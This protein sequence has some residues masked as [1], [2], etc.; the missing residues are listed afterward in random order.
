MNY[1]PKL[2]QFPP[3]SPKQ[4]RKERN[5][6]VEEYLEGNIKRFF[7]RHYKQY[8]NELVYSKILKH[9][10]KDKRVRILNK[11]LKHTEWPK[12]VC[13]IVNLMVTL[14][15]HYD[16]TY[17]NRC[18]NL[19]VAILDLWE[20]DMYQY[21]SKRYKEKVQKGLWRNKYTKEEAFKEQKARGFIHINYFE[22]YD[23]TYSHIYSNV[24]EDYV[25]PLNFPHVFGDFET[26]IP[27]DIV[28][29]SLVGVSGWTKLQYPTLYKN[30]TSSRRKSIIQN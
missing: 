29:H 26:G 17:N 23:K 20:D 8:N 3:K 11:I 6:I 18:L 5:Q 28:G 15:K 13:E 10:K 2:D 9:W 19:A 16:C 27:S 21:H 4:L 24:D 30:K 1:T 22:D 14:V 12:N 25:F 7:R